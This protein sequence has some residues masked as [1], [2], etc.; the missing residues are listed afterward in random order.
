MRSRS[1]IHQKNKMCCNREEHNIIGGLGDSIAQAAA[2]HLP[3]PIEMLAQMILLAK[4]ENP[5]NC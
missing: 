5:L 1:G 2:K 3:V 4:A